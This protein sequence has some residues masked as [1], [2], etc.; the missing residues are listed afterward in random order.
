LPSSSDIDVISALDG[1]V[2]VSG[3]LEI[4]AV[5]TWLIVREDLSLE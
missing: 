2:T 4:N 3:T 5:H 1:A